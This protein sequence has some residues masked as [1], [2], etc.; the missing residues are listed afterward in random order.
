[1]SRRCGFSAVQ[2]DFRLPAC[3]SPRVPLG[4]VCFGCMCANLQ[5]GGVSHGS[6]CSIAQPHK[7]AAPGSGAGAV[8]CLIRSCSWNWRLAVTPL[9][10]VTCGMPARCFAKGRAQRCASVAG[11]QHYGAVAAAR[12][13]RENAVGWPQACPAH[14]GATC[15]CHFAGVVKV[16][17]QHRLLM[18]VCGEEAESPLCLVVGERRQGAFGEGFRAG[19][20]PTAQTSWG[21]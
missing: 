20:N 12:G 3:R 21:S 14:P 16:Q 19:C 11:L 5:L 2:Q 15:W 6:A 9:E 18:Y 7:C 8:G 4:C 13:C 1:V 10:R 17:G